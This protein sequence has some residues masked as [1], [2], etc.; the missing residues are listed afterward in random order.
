M[1]HPIPFGLVTR[2]ILINMRFNRIAAILLLLSFSTVRAFANDWETGGQTKNSM[3]SSGNWTYNYLIQDGSGNTTRRVNAVLSGANTNSSGVKEVVLTGDVML[4]H[5]VFVGL[6]TN[7]NLPT[8]LIIKNGTD[9]EINFWDDLDNPNDGFGADQFMVLFSVWEG[10]TLIIDGDPDGNGKGKIKFGGNANNRGLVTKYGFIESTGNLELKDVIIEHVKFDQANAEAGEC[11]V[12]KIHPWYVLDSGKNYEQGYTKL[13]N[14]VIRNITMPGGVGAVMY[15]YLKTQNKE[16]NT[17]ERCTI[18]M[19]NVRIHDVSQGSTSNDGNGGIIRFRGDWV[20]NLNMTGVNIYNC[21]SGASSAGVYWNALGRSSEPCEMTLDGCTFQNLTVTGGNAGALL[22]EGRARFANN[23]TKFIGNKCNKYGGAVYI[24]NYNST[25]TPQSGESF[26]YD[27]NQYAYF[28]DNSAD[29]G[30]GLAIYIDDNSSLPQPTDFHVN[31]NGAV[32]KN[33]RA[34]AEAGAMKINLGTDSKNY[35]LS[36]N[37]NSG[38]FEG[39]SAPN[40]GAIYSWRGSVSSAANGSCTFTR[41]TATASGSAIFI[42]KSNFTLRNAEFSN[43]TATNNDGAIYVVNSTMTMDNGYIHDN[44]SGGY[45]GGVHVVNSTMTINNGRINNN[46]AKWRGGGIYLNNSTLYFNDG[47]INGNRIYNSESPDKGEYGG[48]VC[49]IASDFIMTNGEINGN[50]AKLHGGGVYYGNDKG[51]DGNTGVA[52]RKF[53]F[54]GGSISHNTSGG[55]GGGVCIY[56]G[57]KDGCSFN[58]TGG[59]INYNVSENGG[60]VYINGWDKYTINLLNTNIQYNDSYVG[61]GVL[62]Y[63]A[64]L[65]YKNGLIRFNRAKKRDGSTKPAT[66]YQVNHCDNTGS[67]DKV[68]P[69]ISGIGGG[70]HSTWGTTTFDTSEGKFGIYSNIADYG[71]DDIFTNA[72]GTSINLPNPVSMDVIGFEVPKE[73]QFWAQDYIE[74]DTNYDKRPSAAPAVTPQTRY[75]IMLNNL[76]TNLKNTKIPAGT[77]TEY[78]SAALGYCFAPVT[79]IKEGLLAG[80]T[81]IINFYH[82]E[83]SN[84]HGEE[85][86]M[87]L[88]MFNDSKTDGKAVEKQINLLPGTWTLVESNWGWTYTGST[89]GEDGSKTVD[90]Q[91]AIV[92]KNLLDTSPKAERTFKFSNRKNDKT[93]PAKESIKTNVMKPKQ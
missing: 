37:L 91:A 28:E 5:S 84:G 89:E 18:T 10:C 92:R 59:D 61:G 23:Q 64:D 6:S 51:G 50:S 15:C 67:E 68:N 47:H 42:N 3:P 24:H 21:T 9:N 87:Q 63:N 14:T 78:I 43:N 85:P 33:N 39:N 52:N 81:A 56:T 62:V 93:G 12:L 88:V 27:I 20:G 19:N 55:F 54:S 58:L 53:S 90:G 49:A 71:A 79:I 35:N 57:N 86:Y 70:I 2:N 44:L 1:I 7:N 72:Q 76:E 36:L 82:K 80:E 34:S 40:G 73:N 11:S 4:R 41:N 32:F 26:I 46:T 77:Y 83:V 38:T 69:A 30:G 8:T 45:G 31:V 66:M 29:H 16:N 48:G 22:I 17:R 74:G 60:G 65:Y 13:T 25:D 75:R